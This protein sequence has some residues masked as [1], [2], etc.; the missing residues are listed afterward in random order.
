MPNK[1]GM[2]ILERIKE[3]HKKT[4]VRILMTNHQMNK[5]KHTGSE[6]DPDSPNTPI[7]W[8][9]KNLTDLLELGSNYRPTP[10]PTSKE[11]MLISLIRNAL[12]SYHATIKRYNTAVKKAKAEKYPLNIPINTE[13]T[14][15]QK[16]GFGYNYIKTPWYGWDAKT[17][18]E[19][20]NL[21]E[22]EI[23]SWQNN[24]IPEG[25]MDHTELHPDLKIQGG[26]AG[27]VDTLDKYLTVIKN[28]IFGIVLS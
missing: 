10:T 28:H 5:I 20:L 16:R 25:R 7:P 11:D 4:G 8:F 18:E 12:S 3:I 15:E 27:M 6:L 23:T 2:M 14:W 17:G 1:T 13:E 19:W 24:D 9:S 22:K 26:R 21:I